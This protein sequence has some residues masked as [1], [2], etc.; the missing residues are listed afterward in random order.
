MTA[1]LQRSLVV[2]RGE[3]SCM[4]GTPEIAVDSHADEL[5][6]VFD[7]STSCAGEGALRVQSNLLF[8]LD[9]SHRSLLTVNN[10]DNSLV[11]VLTNNAREWTQDAP[12]G[13]WRSFVS[14]VG[15]G[16]WHIWIGFDH[17]AFLM[18]LLLP[19]AREANVA[20]A[21]RVTQILRVVTAFTVAHSITLICA[22]LG[23]L[24]LPSRW[25]EATIAASIVIA[26]V[27]NLLN[28]AARYNIAM[29]F[30][31]GLIH[32]VGFAGALAD[33]A[34]DTQHRVLALFG[35]NLG[36][37]LGQLV[38]VAAVFPILFLWQTPSRVRQRAMVAGSAAMGM[39]GVAWLLER[40][41]LS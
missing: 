1:Y 11:A 28:V 9:D 23:I 33:I 17:L 6:A 31:F 21:E 20:T 10:G 7:M 30:G 5:Y 24:E 41:V 40:T 36:V 4:F 26:A 13:A 16:V 8:E 39:L 14:F 2:A 12:M 37:E 32:G 34:T 18:L 38:V 15:Q 27:A 25:V 29:A 22:A 3:Q 35:F 19:L